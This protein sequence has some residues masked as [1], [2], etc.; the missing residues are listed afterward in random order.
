MVEKI[1]IAKESGS[2]FYT[3]TLRLLED[4][5]VEITTIEPYNEILTFRREQVQQR[6]KL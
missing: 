3:G 5:W 1:E 2:Y 6:L 4:G